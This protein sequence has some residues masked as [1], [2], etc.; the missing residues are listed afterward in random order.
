MWETEIATISGVYM[1][2]NSPVVNILLLLQ[3]FVIRAGRKP[4]RDVH[5]D[6]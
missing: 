6:T 5:Y 4:V 1:I 2:P 3:L